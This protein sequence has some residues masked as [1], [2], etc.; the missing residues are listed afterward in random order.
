MRKWL[1]LALPALVLA[2]CASSKAP[3][4]GAPGAAAAE[5][6]SQERFAQLTGGKPT[7]IYYV[8]EDCG[9]NPRAIPLVTKLVEAYK[10]KVNIIGVINADEM[11]YREWARQY[12]VP[13]DFV[14]DPNIEIIRKYA[15]PNSQTLTLIDGS[16]KEI[17]RFD[18]YGAASLN[19]CAAEMASVGKVEAAALQLDAPDRASYG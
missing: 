14:Y 17:K 11:A 8:K 4:A 18:G 15:V 10:G 1:I 9:S 5:Q 7:F 3:E 6:S 13:I 12:S 16:G 2:G 19:A